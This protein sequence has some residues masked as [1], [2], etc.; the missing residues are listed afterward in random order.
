MTERRG[1]CSQILQKE[2]LKVGNQSSGQGKSEM[3]TWEGE[4]LLRF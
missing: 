3:H 4:A 1:K 2:F